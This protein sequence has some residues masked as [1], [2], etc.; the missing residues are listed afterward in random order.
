MSESFVTPWTI[1]LHAS[2]FM[3]FSRQKY[4][5]GLPLPTPRDLPDSGIKP[6][7][8]V[9]PVLAGGFFTTNTNWG[10]LDSNSSPILPQR[11]QNF[12]I[13]QLILKVLVNVIVF[14]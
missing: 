14:L 3:G 6:S 13:K 2:L 8:L 11:I 7:S 1:A 5:N 4:W 12:Y 9:S 10:V